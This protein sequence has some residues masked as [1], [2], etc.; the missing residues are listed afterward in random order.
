M[1]SCYPG[2]SCPPSGIMSL[3]IR[4]YGTQWPTGTQWLWPCASNCELPLRSMF[5]LWVWGLMAKHLYPSQHAKFHLSL[6]GLVSR[7]LIFEVF[8]EAVFPK[9]NST[10]MTYYL[11][12][13]SYQKLLYSSNSL[14]L[15][16]FY[17]GLS[18]SNGERPHLTPSCHGA[19]ITF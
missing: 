12:S 15:G 17:I 18:P 13:N 3:L 9:W 8:W 5:W 16:F 11:L 2:S 1:N 14:A 4:A 19:F 7:W 6:A 10:C